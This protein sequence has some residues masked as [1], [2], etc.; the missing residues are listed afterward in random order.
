VHLVA[1]F[2]PVD[3]N[4]GGVLSALW[5]I[6]W[7]LSWPLITFSTV[8][9]F[10]TLRFNCWRFLCASYTFWCY[11]DRIQSKFHSDARFYTNR[12]EET[13]KTRSGIGMLKSTY[14]RRMN[15][16][17]LQKEFTRLRREVR[18]IHLYLDVKPPPL[19]FHGTALLSHSS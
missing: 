15:F 6:C 5:Y 18:W 11:H 16:G 3:R 4:D 10:P 7:N 14:L 9:T 19:S 17:N 1:D 8:V 13:I 12:L 2:E